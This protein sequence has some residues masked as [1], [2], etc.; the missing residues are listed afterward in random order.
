MAV[1]A[2]WVRSLEARVIVLEAENRKLWGWI[3]FAIGGCTAAAS[4]LGFFATPLILA[5]KTY[6]AGR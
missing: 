2:E 6:V 3:R 1:D 5:A 4:I